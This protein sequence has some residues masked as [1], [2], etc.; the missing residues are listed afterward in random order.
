MKRAYLLCLVLVCF[1]F[2]LVASR[3][4]QILEIQGLTQPWIFED[5]ET[6]KEFDRVIELRR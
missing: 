5:R 3:Y 2:S 1:F 4:D 6:A